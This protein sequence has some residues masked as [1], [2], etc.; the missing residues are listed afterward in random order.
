MMQAGDG[1]KLLS[2]DGI[3][4]VKYLSCLDDQDYIGSMHPLHVVVDS[5]S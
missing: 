5:F 2:E 4:Q 3:F 1:S